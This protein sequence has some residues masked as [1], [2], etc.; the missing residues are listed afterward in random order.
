MPLFSISDKKLKEVKKLNF[1][2]E[3]DIQNITE[4]NLREIFG[5]RLIGSEFSINN[6][7][8]DSLAFD[9]ENNS[10]VII[11]YK[12]DKNSSVID[13]GYAYL[14]L[15]LNNKS[16]FILEFNEN[17]N[18][19][20][21]R[22]DV[23]WSQSRVIFIYPSF[24][25]YQKQAINFNDLPFELWEVSMFENKM[26]QYK[27]LKP[28]TS[29]ESI[30]K[31]SKG[32]NLVDKVNSE[33]KVYS[34]EDHLIKSNN[35]IKKI[36]FELKNQILSINDTIEYEPKKKYISFK[37]QNN[38]VYFVFKKDKIKIYLNLK[39]GELQDSS[40]LARDV[41]NIG[42]WGYGDYEV[43]VSKEEEIPVTFLL[44]KQSYDKNN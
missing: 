4:N 39:K 5:L 17:S 21:K 6:L 43:T 7:R 33:V 8:F 15:M 19:S 13:Q 16:D 37:S 44:I 18:S 11:E 30:K 42:H 27:Q 34:E 38:F 9:E 41:S 10:F 14:S 36:Y 3:K 29:S 24:S 26:I 1:K 40:K 23:D 12:K 28:F 25:K 22:N 2:L 20:L 32:N 35:L 31:I